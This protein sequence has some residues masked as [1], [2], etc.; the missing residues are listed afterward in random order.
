MVPTRQ[1][2]GLNLARPSEAGDTQALG[3]RK[4]LEDVSSDR[5]SAG[6]SKVCQ[7]ELFD[8]DRMME[9]AAYQRQAMPYDGS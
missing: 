8:L 3:L 6:V 1:K 5:P 2:A 9:G 7:H 4:H